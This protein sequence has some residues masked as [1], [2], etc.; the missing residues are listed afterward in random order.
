MTLFEFSQSIK[1]LNIDKKFSETLKFFKENKAAFTP[2]QI[3][4]NKYVFFEMITALIETIHYLVI[5]AFIE[6]YKV[7]FQPK[8]FSFF[9]KNFKHKPSV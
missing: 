6:Q 1:A 8:Y 5:F 7:A 4:L 9:F 2:E 3:G